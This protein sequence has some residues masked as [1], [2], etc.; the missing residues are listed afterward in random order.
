MHNYKWFLLLVVVC[1]GASRADDTA[2]Q[3]A[4]GAYLVKMGDCAACHTAKQGKPFAGGLKISTPAGAIY[5]TNITPD[6]ETGIGDYSYDDFARAMR[7][8][9]AKDGHR[10]YPA[11]PYPS[12]AK[13][14]DEDM[15]AL[16]IWF[17]YGVKPVSQAN[18]ENALPW[19]LSMRWTL[20]LWNWLFVDDGFVPDTAQSAEWERGAYLVQ[21]LGH[22]GACHTPRGVA[23]QEKALDQ[24]E[25]GYLRGARLDGWYAPDLTGYS[26]GGPGSW[27]QDDIRSWLKTG[28]NG[29]S[30]AFGPM[31]EVVEK[32]TQYL[33]DN[34]ADAIAVY[35]RSLKPA[36]RVISPPAND[37]A[38]GMELA[39]GN[40]SQTGA[41]EYVDNC[42]ACH[43]LDGNG[44]TSTFPA[45][46][47]NSVVLSDD[48]SSLINLV[49]YGGRTPVTRDAL[50]GL[51]MPAFGWRLNDQQAADVV[52]FIRNGW[53]NRASVVT[54]EQ[55][56]ALRNRESA[57]AGK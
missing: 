50:S 6:K 53:G 10:L 51:P 9:V 33:T 13:I 47:Q 31:A 37:P 57:S 28:H 7:K 42:A 16:Y 26:H 34:D 38:T 43:R 45:L 56:K 48:P 18:R 32:S 30:A 40:D 24:R 19:P 49:L 46:A 39:R 8:G 4:R 12:F 27:S 54:A 25:E 52:T 36:R 29:K 3:L 11:M 5:S 44:Y 1:C 41:K 14:N 20:A 17:M 2:E 21:G 23:F 22:C 55:V 15:S 35:L